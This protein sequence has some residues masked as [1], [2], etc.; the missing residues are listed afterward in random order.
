MIMVRLIVAFYPFVSE[1][2]RKRRRWPKREEEGNE[3]GSA[4]RWLPFSISF[5]ANQILCDFFLSLS[6]GEQRS[7][8]AFR[9]ARGR[10][11]NTFDA[12]T[13]QTNPFL[14]QLMP[15]RCNSPLIRRPASSSFIYF[16]AHIYDYLCGNSP[17]LSCRRKMGANV[18]R[19]KIHNWYL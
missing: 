12:V 13:I 14:L 19:I 6:G 5:S 3:T 18:R 10:G 16:N 1:R 17:Q 9:A 8:F 4:I 15:T 7:S 11:A 2:A